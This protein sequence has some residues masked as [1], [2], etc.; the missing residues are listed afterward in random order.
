MTYTFSNPSIMVRVMEFI[1]IFGRINVTP[2]MIK[3]TSPQIE[4]AMIGDRMRVIVKKAGI[5]DIFER[6]LRRA[7]NCVGCGA[8][9][10]ACDSNALE[11]KEGVLT[12]GDSC[13]HCL[14]CVTSN[15]IRMSCVSVNY[16]PHILAVT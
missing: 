8:C 14:H 5:L 2:L 6:Q 4:I 16:K 9:V 13:T 11:V 3:V 12:V 7:L 10:G 1:K 15:G